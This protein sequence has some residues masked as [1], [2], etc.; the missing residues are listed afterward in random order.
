[1]VKLPQRPDLSIMQAVW[2]Y[3]EGKKRQMKFKKKKKY[4]KFSK[5]LGTTNL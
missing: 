5:M 4:D 1:M 3:T 2:D